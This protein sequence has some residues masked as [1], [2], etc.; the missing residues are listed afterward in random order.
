L[1]ELGCQATELKGGWKVILVGAEASRDTPGDV[2]MRLSPDAVLQQ[3]RVMKRNGGYMPRL[4]AHNSFCR[5]G[6]NAADSA[7]SRRRYRRRSL[8]WEA[9]TEDVSKSEAVA[10]DIRTFM[11]TAPQRRSNTSTLRPLATYKTSSLPQA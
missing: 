2:A 11:T 1:K 4:I 7:R 3:F 10:A 8:R 6:I 5:S 9:V